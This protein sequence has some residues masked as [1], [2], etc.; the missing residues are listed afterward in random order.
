[1]KKS[2]FIL[3]SQLKEQLQA[4]PEIVSSLGKKRSS[5]C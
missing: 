1:M 5:F 4:F 2:Q 3:V